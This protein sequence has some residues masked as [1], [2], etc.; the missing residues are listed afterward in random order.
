M[1][2]LLCH[3]YPGP[4]VA[5]APRPRV[6]HACMPGAL[7]WAPHTRALHTAIEQCRGMGPGTPFGFQRTGTTSQGADTRYHLASPQLRRAAAVIPFQPE[8]RD[9]GL[10]NCPP[11]YPARENPQPVRSHV[12]RVCTVW[13]S[14]MRPRL[15]L[16]HGDRSRHMGGPILLSSLAGFHVYD[17]LTPRARATRPSSSTM[18]RPR[19]G[20]A[21][22]APPRRTTGLGHPKLIPNRTDF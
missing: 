10:R 19:E 11:D 8:R 7:P 4:T 5:R 20:E 6:R 9:R 3:A 16:P 22:A 12:V 14:A 18:R 21:A 2:A 15:P 13:T 1:C 17:R